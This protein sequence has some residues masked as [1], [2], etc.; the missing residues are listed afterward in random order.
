MLLKEGC[1]GNSNFKTVSGSTMHL[2]RIQEGTVQPEEIQE[3]HYDMVEVKERELIIEAE[4][5]PEIF[6]MVQGSLKEHVTH[7]S[8]TGKYLKVVIW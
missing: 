1:F 4:P 5:V 3:P 7:I 2:E 6:L 8:D